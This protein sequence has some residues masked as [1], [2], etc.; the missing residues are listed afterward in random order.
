MTNGL[1]RRDRPRFSFLANETKRASAGTAGNIRQRVIGDD[2]DTITAVWAPN[3]QHRTFG[4]TTIAGLMLQSFVRLG[5]LA[6][7]P[8]GFVS[9]F[10]YDLQLVEFRLQLR[11]QFRVNL[12]KRLVRNLLAVRAAL[13]NFI[14]KPANLLVL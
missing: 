7:A 14:D 5:V 1:D 6:F 3:M 10:S 11:H 8:F 9:G 2:F 12:D 4:P 13:Q